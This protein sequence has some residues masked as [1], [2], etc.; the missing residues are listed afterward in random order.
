MNIRSRGFVAA[1]EDDVEVVGMAS[2]ELPAELHE[3]ASEVQDVAGDMVDD[4]SDVEAAVGDAETLDKIADTAEASAEEGEG[5][6]PVSA[7]IAEVAVES[8]YARLGLNKKATPSMEAFGST[9]SR[10]A[11]TRIAVEDWKDTV[12]RVWESVKKFFVSIWEKV[13]AL[14]QRFLDFFRSL[15][16]AAVSMKSRVAALKGEAKE[17]KFENAS[18]AKAFL[19]EGSAENVA[20]VLKNQNEFMKKSSD[21]AKTLTEDISLMTSDLQKESKETKAVK[22]EEEILAEDLVAGKKVKTGNKDGKPFF[23]V[24][25]TT[26]TEGK[27]VKTLSKE[28]MTKVCDKVIALAR[29]I[30]EVKKTVA[31]VEKATKAVSKAAEVVATAVEKENLES[32]KKGASFITKMGS[33]MLKVQS[34]S[35]STSTQAGKSALSYV[36]ASMGKYGEKKEEKKAA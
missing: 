24:V 11:A 27:S 30:S 32:A 17:E 3:E 29:D 22:D 8:I 35:I 25:E 26:K 34:V 10:K 15:E 1:M 5:M 21:R 2:N 6:D 18:I 16:K 7:E 28:E 12:K 14:F 20:K 4:V 9:G 23:E 33:T 31:S 36:A 13:K 19:G